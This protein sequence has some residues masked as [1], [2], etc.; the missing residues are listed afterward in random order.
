MPAAVH[1]GFISMLIKL[2]KKI[3]VTTGKTSTVKTLVGVLLPY[4]VI[5][6]S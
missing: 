2:L 1:Y 4:P 6:R 5:S 3:V